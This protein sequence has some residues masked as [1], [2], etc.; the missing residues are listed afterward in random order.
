MRKLSIPLPRRWPRLVKHGLLSAVALER[1]ALSEV[2]SGF[3]HSRDPRTRMTAELDTLREQNELQ[4][5]ELRILR[6]RLEHIP[7]QQRPH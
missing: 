7:P 3:E 5:E 2:R 1:L 4:A 6:A